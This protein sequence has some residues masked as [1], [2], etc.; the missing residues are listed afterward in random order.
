MDGVGCPGFGDCRGGP[1]F[2]SIPDIGTIRRITFSGSGPAI[3]GAD[4]EVA[5]LNFSGTSTL[6]TSALNW[7]GSTA[8]SFM[9]LNGSV[10]YWPYFVLTHSAISNTAAAPG[11]GGKGKGGGQNQN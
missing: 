2:H 8:N 11:N 10:R 9:T 1:G 4:N 5:T 7:T 3:T 6:G